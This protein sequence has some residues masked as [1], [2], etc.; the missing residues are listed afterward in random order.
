MECM[1]FVNRTPLHRSRPRDLTAK[2][3]IVLP[4]HRPISKCLQL[5]WRKAGLQKFRSV[6]CENQSSTGR[7]TKTYATEA[8]RQPEQLKHLPL[9]GALW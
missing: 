8:L 9:S 7:N 3:A 4:W 6:S 1:F 5:L 2:D